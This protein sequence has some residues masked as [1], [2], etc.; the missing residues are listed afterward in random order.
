MIKVI[1]ATSNPGKA[2]EVKNIFHDLNINIISLIEL[3]DVPEIIEDADSYEGNAKIKAKVIYDKFKLPVISDDSGLSVEQLNGQ[4]G[5]HSARY[6]GENCTYA[7]NN[8]KLLKE[9]S[10]FEEP[11]FAKFICC[12][13]YFNG[14]EFTTVFGEIKGKVIS[15]ERG[16]NGFGYDPVF[17][18]EEFGYM[19]TLAELPL[20]QKNK[21]SHRFRAF[22]QLKQK[23]VTL[24]K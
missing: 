10:K 16:E 11:H 24:K 12:A 22:T 15:E 7:D 2:K 21:I 18:P 6:A 5:V 3:D 14:A 9:L 23:L 8:R 20:E 4:P 13:V 1:F 19:K 17:I